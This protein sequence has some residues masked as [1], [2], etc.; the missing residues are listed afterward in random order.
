M[1]QPTKK[2]KKHSTSMRTVSSLS[3]M[4]KH[5]HQLIFRL[6]D[7]RMQKDLYS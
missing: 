5:F 7:E 1:A 2:A 4:G 6:P 3:F